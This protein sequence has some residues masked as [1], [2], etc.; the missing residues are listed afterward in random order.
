MKKAFTLAEV[1]ITLVIIGVIAAMTIPSLLNNTNK[2]ETKTAVKKAYSALSQAI[3]QHY[4]LTGQTYFDLLKECD[5]ESDCMYQNFFSKRM[6]IVSSTNDSQA[7]SY[8]DVIFYTSDGMAYSIDWDYISVDINGDKKPNEYTD[9]W[10]TLKDG[11]GFRINGVYDDN[12]HRVAEKV[13]GY[14]PVMAIISGRDCSQTPHDCD[15]CE[16][17]LDE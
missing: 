8:G 6:N 9:S 17:C 3:T 1:L 10:Q 11:Y 14:P 13:D 12:G 2:E 15:M 16:S 5:Y 4:A 7:Y